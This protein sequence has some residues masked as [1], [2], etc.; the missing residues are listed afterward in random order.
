MR[1]GEGAC[2]TLIAVRLV[3]DSNSVRIG[4][5]DVEESSVR[6]SLFVETSQR[7]VPFRL[8]QPD[9][10]RLERPDEAVVHDAD[11]DRLSG[12]QDIRD[13]GEVGAAATDCERR[14]R[15]ARGVG[16]ECK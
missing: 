6:E 9:F 3:A 5:G 7:S 12:L 8:K 10:S 2:L 16:G 15:F 13:D 4:I 11:R 1:T 14:R